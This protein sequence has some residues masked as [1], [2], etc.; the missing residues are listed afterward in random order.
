MAGKFKG[1]SSK[2]DISIDDLIDL[3]HSAD[4]EKVVNNQ[5]AV[6]SDEALAAL[7]DRTM[8]ASTMA[9]SKTSSVQSM[10]TNHSDVFKVIAER[11]SIENLISLDN[12]CTENS[13][14]LGSID[15]LSVYSRIEDTPA[16]DSDC[17]VEDAPAKDSGC[18]VEDAPAKD[19]GCDLSSLSSKFSS[20]SPEPSSSTVSCTS[21]EFL[22]SSSVML[23]ET[24]A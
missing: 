18:D 19:S 16:K 10:A 12:V 11:D 13:R 9:G 14:E 5:D 24:D 3:L 4:H 22:S 21:S 1:L 23:L 2:Y 20:I 7:L 17:D 6:M 8:S 15:A